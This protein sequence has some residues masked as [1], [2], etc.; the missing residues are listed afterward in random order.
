MEKNIINEINR[1][2]ELMSLERLNLISESVTFLK[3][4]GA[5]AAEAEVEKFIQS[6]AKKLALEEMKKGTVT[7]F[8]ADAKTFNKLSKDTVDNVIKKIE[9]ESGKS[10]TNAQKLTIEQDIR[11]TMVEEIKKSINQQTKEL[12]EKLGRKTPSDTWIAIKN[13]F[14][15]N[16]VAY[17]ALAV[18]IFA[19][20]WPNEPTP[21]VEDDEVEDRYNVK[22]NAINC[23]WV[24][25][26]GSADVEG[27]K[28]SGWQCPKPG[29]RSNY[30]YCS[31]FPFKKYC[32]NEKIK[33]IQKCI[34][35]NP[36]GV[37]G[38]ETERKLEEK[39]YPTE[40]T[41]EVYNRIMQD[42]ASSTEEVYQEINPLTIL[43]SEV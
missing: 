5:E 43:S 42:C 24:N 25:S 40:I 2:R 28:N 26:D 17:T 1:Y 32:K 21:N 11:R 6:E 27:Y 33:E 3:K 38:P 14:K 35:A 37:Y 15:N 30:N 9:S 16:W 4:V 19:L 8:R 31:D 10:L 23:G 36:D 29:S 39:G 7:S 22:Q 41:Q 12:A 34:G 18:A 20:L 13:H